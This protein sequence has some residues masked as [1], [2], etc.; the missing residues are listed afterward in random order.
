MRDFG[1][2]DFEGFYKK[3]P[4]FPKGKYEAYGDPA[5]MLMGVDY[6]INNEGEGYCGG[7]HKSPNYNV[8]VDF[9]FFVREWKEALVEASA[10]SGVPVSKKLL[11]INDRASTLKESRMAFFF[12]NHSN[13]TDEERDM[14]D[15]ETWLM[16]IYSLEVFANTNSDLT[17]GERLFLGEFSGEMAKQAVDFFGY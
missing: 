13:L 14:V 17:S 9:S 16:K 2:F 6:F 10:K 1:P 8:W 15:H 7:N 3:Y 5:E 4:K 12:K 11:T